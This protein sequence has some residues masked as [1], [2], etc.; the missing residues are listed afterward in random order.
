MR[1]VRRY[2]NRKLYDSAE[3]RYITLGELFDLVREGEDVKVIDSSRKD[4]TATTLF[5]AVLERGKES[6]SAALTAKVVLNIIKHGDGTLA[7]F[8]KHTIQKGA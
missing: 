3:S 7:G 4:V 1:I 6:D 8:I 5:M 2:K